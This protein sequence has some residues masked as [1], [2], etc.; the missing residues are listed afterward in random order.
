MSEE[1]TDIRDPSCEVCRGLDGAHFKYREE[2]SDTSPWGA[3]RFHYVEFSELRESASKSCR[4]CRILQ[5]G[6]GFFWGEDPARSSNGNEGQ[7]KGEEQLEGELKLEEQT[8]FMGEKQLRNLMR[9]EIRP[10]QSLLVTRIS[11]TL[12]KG[13]LSSG[14]RAPLEFYTKPG[15]YLHN[16]VRFFNI[17]IK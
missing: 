2:G 11:D 13:H 12:P 4:L 14:M 10:E 6:I 9:I 17:N 1:F 16:Q 15:M 3:I 8:Q 7:L 5:Q